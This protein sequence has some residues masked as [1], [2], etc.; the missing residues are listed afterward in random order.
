MTTTFPTS[1]DTKE[2]LPYLR[3]FGEQTPP[4]VGSDDL[5]KDLRDAVVQLEAAVGIAGASARKQTARSEIFNIDN[6]AGTT[7]DDVILKL[8]YAIT[9][10][11][12][13][14]VYV[15]ATTGTVAAGNA[16][17]GSTLAGAEVVAATAY[18]DSKAVGVSTPMTV[19]TA[20][21]ANKIAANGGV[22]V[23]HTG[24]AVTAAGEA[25]VEVEFTID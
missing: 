4:G 23:R 18:E 1:L 12:A 11:S 2:S 6:G 7:I 15:H 9:I 3:P 16:K 8:P 5:V 19:I 13:R 22:F 17:I 14:I 10:Q 21:N 24:I 20:A 25:Y